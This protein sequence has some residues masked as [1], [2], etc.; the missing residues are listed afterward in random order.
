MSERVLQRGR[1]WDTGIGRVAGRVAVITGASAGMGVEIARLL[2]ACGAAVTIVGR[3]PARLQA[4]L[5]AV[6][7]VGGVGHMVQVDLTAPESAQRIVDQT[8]ERF[9]CLDI[10][11]HCAGA[12]AP[13]PIEDAMATF[14]TEWQLNVWGA[15]N[16]TRLALPHLRRRRGSVLFISS[17]AASRAF[18]NS[19]G[20]CAT[21]GAVANLVRALAVE[22]APNGVRVNAIAPGEINTPL[23]AENLKDPE[24]VASIM[25]STPLGRVGEVQDIAPA[26]V[27]LVSADASYITGASLAV[28]GG[29]SAQ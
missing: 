28:D 20:Y 14:E 25:R 7:D 29:W 4:T 12:F 6:T 19:T 27:F 9:G 21:K 3:D 22:E 5:D 1:T 8:V 15:Y 26:A 10:L 11:V 16:L 17:V 23:N 13:A 2:A 18:P 24:Y